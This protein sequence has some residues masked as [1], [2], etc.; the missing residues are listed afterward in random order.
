MIVWKAIYTNTENG[1]GASYHATKADA[2]TVAKDNGGG[3]VE[4]VS[5]TGREEAVNALNCAIG[6]GG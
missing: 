5:I 6:Y 1:R 4:K 2:N 3:N